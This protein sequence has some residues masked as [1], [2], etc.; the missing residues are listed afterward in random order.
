[1]EGETISLRATISHIM[2]ILLIVLALAVVIAT[3]LP[4]LR[5]DQWWIRIFDF[6]RAQLTITGILLLALY[7][8]FWD[9]QRLYETIILGLLLLAVGYQVIKMFPY[10]V[11]MPKQVMTAESASDHPRIKILVANVLMENR[12]STAFMDMVRKYDPDVILTVET[13]KWWEKA[14]RPLEADYPHT[15]KNPL[16][17]TYGILFYSRLDVIDP[18]IRFII[19]DSIPSMH[20]QMV[21]PSNERIFMHFVH[22][23]PPNPKYAAETTARDAELLI[24]GREAEKRNK[25]TIVAG[26][27]N[28]VAW[29]YT[30]GLFQKA[31][32]LL[33]P[34]IGRG[35]YNSYSAKSLIMRWPLDHVF[36]SDHFKL[37][38][39]DVRPAWGSD[40]FPIFIELSL[41]QEA[42]AEQ[43]KPDATQREAE[44][45]DE[46][47]EDGRQK[48]NQ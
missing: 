26:D 12:A 9:T 36:H 37:V 23:D 3:I 41:E 25:P 29:S 2:K 33:D 14:L 16:D 35:M 44:Q 22:P 17:N 45:V 24:V 39:M 11:L 42:E 20:M 15:L 8:Y 30:T 34:R 46:M 7:L 21:L 5:F 31:S 47:I 43:E 18:Q 38:R 32:G 1:M 13:N 10:T 40:H 4:L 27:F 28:D 19:K 6:P 48:T